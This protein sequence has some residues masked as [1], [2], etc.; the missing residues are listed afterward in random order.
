[1]IWYMW[2]NKIII[3]HQRKKYPEMGLKYHLTKKRMEGQRIKS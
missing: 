1:M 2:H 3:T